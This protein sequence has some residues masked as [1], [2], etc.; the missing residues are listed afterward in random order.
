MAARGW[1]APRSNLTALS[2]HAALRGRSYRARMPRL[3]RSL[4][5]SGVF[6][7]FK[8]NPHKKNGAKGAG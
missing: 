3:H 5:N 7:E 8:R 2:P 1:A 4:G 6:K